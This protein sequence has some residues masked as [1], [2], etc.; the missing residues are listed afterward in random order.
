MGSQADQTGVGDRRSGGDDGSGRISDEVSRDQAVVRLPGLPRFGGA[1]AVVRVTAAG[2]DWRRAYRRLHDAP[3]GVGFGGGVPSPGREVLCSV[4]GGRRKIVTSSQK[5]REGHTGWRF[6][7][8]GNVIVPS[9]RL[10]AD[11]SFPRLDR[12]KEFETG[13]FHAPLHDRNHLFSS[14]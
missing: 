2:A 9:I 12:V 11:K 7:R 6:G 3:G 13:V 1:E 5:G 8:D 14:T 10:R 4:R